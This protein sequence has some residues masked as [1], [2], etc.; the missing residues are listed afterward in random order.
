M[1]IIN[2]D[3]TADGG[4]PRLFYYPGAAVQTGTATGE[5]PRHTLA[6]TTFP[7][8]LGL[9]RERCEGLGPWGREVVKV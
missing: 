9:I 2:D 5:L 7:S 1:T 8:L 6:G 4:A 3:D